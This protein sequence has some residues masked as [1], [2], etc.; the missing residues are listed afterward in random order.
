MEVI[1]AIS[2]SF[3]E[4]KVTK[5][6]AQCQVFARS[7]AGRRPHD[8]YPIKNLPCSRLIWKCFIHRK[9]GSSNNSHDVSTQS[10]MCVRVYSS[11]Y[12]DSGLWQQRM[13]HA[14]ENFRF[15][16]LDTRAM[17][18]AARICEV[19]KAVNEAVRDSGHCYGNL[20]PSAYS[21]YLWS[22]EQT[23]NLHK[24]MRRNVHTALSLRHT[25][26]C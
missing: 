22:L 16:I 1:E 7:W 3:L 26:L 9:F 8:K 14:K 2:T 21:E 13:P 5:R 15:V 17:V 12:R 24:I 23:E 10:H 25:I 20:F 11:Q 19:L 18:S 4:K 6:F